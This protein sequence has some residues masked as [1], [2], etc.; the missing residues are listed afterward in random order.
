MSEK[1]KLVHCLECDHVFEERKKFIETCPE[2]GNNDTQST[3]Y[4]GIN[5]EEEENT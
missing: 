5:D 2:C 1:P 3:V 4:M